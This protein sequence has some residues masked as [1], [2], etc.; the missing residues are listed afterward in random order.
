[1]KS[2]IR[3]LTFLG[4]TVALGASCYAAT[5]SGTVKDPDGAPFQGAFVQAQ[6]TKTRMTFMA[7]SDQQGHYRVEKLPA[8]E[9]QLQIKATGFRGDPRNGVTLQAD[10]N[11][12]FDFAMQKAPVRWNEISIYQAKK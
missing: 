2:K 8:G 10:Q 7:L 11:A 5:V 3:L 9:Y 4:M 12:S 1:M 6:N